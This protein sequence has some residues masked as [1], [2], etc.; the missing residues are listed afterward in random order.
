MGTIIDSSRNW[1]GSAAL[2]RFQLDFWRGLMGKT[3]MGKGIVQSCSVKFP[4]PLLAGEPELFFTRFCPL[5][6]LC[7]FRFPLLGGG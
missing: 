5:K 1:G 4:V 6:S 2:P 3:T 7:F